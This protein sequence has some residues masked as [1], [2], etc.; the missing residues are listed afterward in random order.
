MAAWWDS[1]SV[2]LLLFSGS[3]NQL[4]LRQASARRCRSKSQFVAASRI[5]RSESQFVAFGRAAVTRAVVGL[6]CVRA[7]TSGITS[8]YGFHTSQES[9]IRRSQAQF[10]ASGVT[11]FPCDMF[12]RLKQL[13]LRRA[14]ARTH[15]VPRAVGQASGQ[16]RASRDVGASLGKEA[17]RSRCRSAESRRG[18]SANR[19]SVSSRPTEPRV[20]TTSRGSPPLGCVVPSALRSHRPRHPPALAVLRSVATASMSLY[21]CH[22]RVVNGYP[23]SGPRGERPVALRPSRV[24]FAATKWHE[25]LV[26][27]PGRGYEDRGSHTV[28]QS[29]GRRFSLDMPPSR[30]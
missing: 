21:F 28:T 30:V 29:R 16:A 6:S 4:P 22:P 19:S 20:L 14:S 17:R 10:V 7:S 27:L 3:V 24:R 13:P 11:L 1:C 26:S 9:A 18:K 25:C 8:E 12:F 5:R 2:R 15:L 23:R